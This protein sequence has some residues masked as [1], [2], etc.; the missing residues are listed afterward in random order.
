MC[1]AHLHE[2][3]LARLL[4]H[5]VQ[6]RLHLGLPLQEVRV[7]GGGAMPCRLGR[8]P[9]LIR[10]A[11]G[12]RE[13][14]HESQFGLGNAGHFRLVSGTQ[15]AC[16]GR[17]QKFHAGRE[18]KE[19]GSK[20]RLAGNATPGGKQDARRDVGE[21]AAPGGRLGRRLAQK[22]DLTV[23]LDRRKCVNIMTAALRPEGAEHSS[24]S[25]HLRRSCSLPAGA[26]D[27]AVPGGSASALSLCCASARLISSKSSRVQQQ[28]AAVQEEAWT[29]L[30]LGQD[31]CNRRSP[32]A[33]KQCDAIYSTKG[34]NR[35]AP[36]AVHFLAELP[37]G[38]GAVDCAPFAFAMRMRLLVRSTGCPVPSAFEADSEQTLQELLGQLRQSGK[39]GGPFD[40]RMRLV[41]GLITACLI[42]RRRRRCCLLP[43]W[44]S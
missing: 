16:G 30:A 10:V 4:L 1:E 23:L 39:L 28:C 25:A 13:R 15:L 43:T 24:P 32:M 14:R 2:L 29:L 7:A 19:E 44:F 33:A 35:G 3:C 38:P 41:R 31:C 17:S 12:C 36:N 5:P 8:P 11:V 40:E 18:L 21:V 42:R 34:P 27:Q 9:Q 20:L 22:A 6:Q 37:L 26:A